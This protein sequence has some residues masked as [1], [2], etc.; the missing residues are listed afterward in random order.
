MELRMTQTLVKEYLKKQMRRLSLVKGNQIMDQTE[1]YTMVAQQGNVV[2]IINQY[3]QFQSLSN[4][5]KAS[6]GLYIWRHLQSPHFPEAMPFPL[7]VNLE[8]P[9]DA[10]P[11]EVARE[12]IAA[13]TGFIPDLHIEKKR[14]RGR[15]R[16][17]KES[18]AC[19]ICID[20]TEPEVY[21]SAKDCQGRWPRGK[22]P[23]K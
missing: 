18:P 13:M 3:S 8:R 15:A 22:C 1:S 2:G 10:L 7:P 19:D 11:I 6:N 14:T 20:S 12:T 5:D 16:E 23:R 21:N 17:P 9:A 4:K